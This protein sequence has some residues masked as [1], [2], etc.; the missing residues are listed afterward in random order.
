VIKT[1]TIGGTPPRLLA[2]IKGMV[3][4]VFITLSLVLEGRRKKEKRVRFARGLRL[5]DGE[6]GLVAVLRLQRRHRA[7]GEVVELVRSGV[8]EGDGVAGS[9]L[10]LAAGGRR[11][12]K[13]NSTT[14][15]FFVCTLIIEP[16]RS[17]SAVPSFLKVTRSSTPPPCLAYRVG[18]PMTVSDTCLTPLA[19]VRVDEVGGQRGSDDARHDDDYGHDWGHRTGSLLG[20][21]R[22]TSASTPI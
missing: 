13:L 9:Q 7:V 20:P 12:A 1:V 22:F 19:V 10:Q 14:V 11:R 18:W 21:H 5:G 3:N 8:H 17:T 15:L 6:A 2:V 4:L 16:V